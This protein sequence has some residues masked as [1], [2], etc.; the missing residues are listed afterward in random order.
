MLKLE[1]YL[2]MIEKIQVKKFGNLINSPI[3]SS[4]YNFFHILI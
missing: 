1:I 2:Q 4:V 3:E